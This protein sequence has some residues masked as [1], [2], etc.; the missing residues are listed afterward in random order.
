M[1]N[2][3]LTTSTVTQ[4]IKKVTDDLCELLIEKNKSYGNSAIDP[5]RIFSKSNAKEQLYVRIDDKLSRIIRG[6]E[7]IGDDTLTDLIGYLILLKVCIHLKGENEK[8]ND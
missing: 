2:N 7:Y 4:T 5:I 1:A 8:D 3:K 6:N